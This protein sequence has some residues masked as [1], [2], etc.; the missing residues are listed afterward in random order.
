MTLIRLAAMRTSQIGPPHSV[1]EPDRYIGHGEDYYCEQS[2]VSVQY[3]DEVVNV[4]HGG[5]SP[6]SR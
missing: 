3:E 4:Y 6:C 5:S 2:R 1:Y